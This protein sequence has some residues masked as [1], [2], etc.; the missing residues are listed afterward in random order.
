MEQIAQ[1]VPR[2]GRTEV[3]STNTGKPGWEGVFTHDDMILMERMGR[4]R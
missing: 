3:P 2:W 4:V 1:A